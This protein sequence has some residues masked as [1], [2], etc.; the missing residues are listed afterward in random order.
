M[1]LTFHQA[2][3]SAAKPLIGIYAES[4]TGKTYSALLLARGFVGPQG[5]IGMI[6]TE[7]GRGEAYADVIDGGYQ[8]LSL[9]D[10]SPKTY[11][12]AIKAAEDAGLDALIIDS[13]SHEWEGIGGVL[14][15]AA[16]NQRKYKGGAI[17]WQKPK[18]DH[19]KHFVGRLLQTPIPLVIV[20]MRAKYPMEQFVNKKG[21]ND[22]RRSDDLSPKQSEDMLFELFVHGWIDRQHNWHGTKY[23][24]PNIGEVFQDGRPITY[25]TGKRLASWAAGE[26]PA[27]EEPSPEIQTW[28]GLIRAADSVGA[29]MEI[30]VQLKEAGLE[31]VGL[32]K[33]R[34]V[35]AM[36][37][38]D[39]G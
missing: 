39:L 16:E 30:G 19:N 27:K 38:A 34:K 3:R 5:K 14:D 7:S 18:V 9:T 12:E 25:D 6:E 22:W 32:K 17:V 28:I 10:F 1:G 33:V 23:S 31:G 8:C 35:F 37:K 11:G 20:C 13:A 4:G 26:E 15:M 2:K 24:H 21:K 36:R 29:L